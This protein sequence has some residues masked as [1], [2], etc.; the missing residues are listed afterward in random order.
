MLTHANPD[1]ISNALFE[2]LDYLD[3]E[4][5]YLLT[6]RFGGPEADNMRKGIE[7]LLKLSQWASAHNKEVKVVPIRR[8]YSLLEEREI[9]QYEQERFEKWM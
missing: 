7:E 8:F 3:N 5:P 6:Y 2:V 1:E 9:V 4:N